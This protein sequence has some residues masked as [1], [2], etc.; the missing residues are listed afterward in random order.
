MLDETLKARNHRGG[1]NGVVKAQRK[2][3]N[4][5]LRLALWTSAAA[6]GKPPPKLDRPPGPQKKGPQKWRIDMLDR[7]RLRGKQAP[8]AVRRF[9]STT[10]EALRAAKHAA[11]RATETL[12]VAQLTNATAFATNARGALIPGG[13]AGSVGSQKA[14]KREAA[15]AAEQKTEAEARRAD[16]PGYADRT[17]RVA[18][19]VAPPFLG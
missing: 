6:T 8:M 17:Q 1:G 15:A 3:R 19:Q 2:R 11:L 9:A 4:E 18:W 14:A 5:K 12:A 13:E 16:A 10:Y 7:R